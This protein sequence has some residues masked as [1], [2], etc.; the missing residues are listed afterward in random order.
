MNEAGQASVSHE[1]IT[2]G[3]NPFQF[4]AGAVPI[5]V[6]FS[7]PIT[8]GASASYSAQGLLMSHIYLLKTIVVLIGCL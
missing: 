1:L 5:G 4:H 3:S 6:H 8:V 2:L 7:M